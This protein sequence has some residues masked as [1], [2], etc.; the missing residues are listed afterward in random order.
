[1]GKMK[2]A[3]FEEHYPEVYRKHVCPECDRQ[4]EELLDLVAHLKEDHNG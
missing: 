1:M 3:W 2:D 4:F